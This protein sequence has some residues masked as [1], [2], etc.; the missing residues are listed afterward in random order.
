ME[1]KLNIYDSGKIEKTYVANE[2]DIMFGTVEDLV[3]LIDMSVFDDNVS[4]AKLVM[5][6][7][8]MVFGAFSQVKVLLKEVFPGVTDE[9]LK[10]VKIKEIVPLFM[11]LVKYSFNE[12]GLVSKGKN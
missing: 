2:F 6:V 5:L 12:I 9:E 8:K 7:G 1:L 10:R 3:N 4:D 11:E